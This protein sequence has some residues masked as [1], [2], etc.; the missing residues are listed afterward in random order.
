MSQKIFILE[1]HAFYANVLIPKLRKQG[2]VVSH[3]L[4]YKSAE[5]AVS[6]GETFDFA[7]LDVVLTNGKTGIHF[8][9]KYGNKFNKI[10]FV[11]GCRDIQTIETL[12][13]KKWNSVSKQYEIWDDLKDFLTTDREMHISI[14]EAC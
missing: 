4:T 5:E 2:Y 14:D 11:T 9:E 13:N 7:I 3:Y 1:D 8:A 6:N 12:I 10:L